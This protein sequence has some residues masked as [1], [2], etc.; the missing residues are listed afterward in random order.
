MNNM[1]GIKFDFRAKNVVIT[2]AS[3]GI[4][5]SIAKSFLKSGANVINISR[6]PQNT[7]KPAGN[8]YKFVQLDITNLKSVKDWIESYTKNGKRIDIWVNNAGVCLQSKLLQVT[9]EHWDR[10]FETNLKSLFFLSL[11]AAEH[12]K[13]NRNGVIINASSFA[14]VMPSVGSCVYAASKAGVASITKSMAAELAPYG[15]RVNSYCPGVI[16]TDMNK[17]LIRKKKN[18]AD[19]IALGRYGNSDEV[20]QAVLFLCS[21]GASYLTG[22]NIEISGGKYLVQ[23]QT[24]AL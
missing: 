10:T 6:S 22:A 13:K 24:D 12:M 21:D 20:A 14:A 2:G 19:A 8:N 11:F 15:I 4:G 16:E 17:V 1:S 9:E 3:R 18:L 23:N 7:K 5:F